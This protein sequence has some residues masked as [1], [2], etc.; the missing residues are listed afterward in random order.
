[1]AENHTR[2]SSIEKPVVFREYPKVVF[3]WPIAAA[4]LF[5]TLGSFVYQSGFVIEQVDAA[6]A[7]TESG[8]AQISGYNAMAGKVIRPGWGNF[9]FILFFLNVLILAYDFD[10]TKGVAVFLG[11]VAV[12]L[13]L[14]YLN[15]QFQMWGW[16][17]DQI[18]KVNITFN[19]HFMWATALMG[20]MTASVIFIHAKFNW[21]ELTHNELI[22]RKR[23]LGDTKRYPALNCRM[24][25]EIPDVMEYFFFFG[26]GRLVFQIPGEN[27]AHVLEHVP[28]VD[29]RELQI[30]EKLG[31]MSIR[32]ESPDYSPGDPGI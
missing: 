20:L 28:F 18:S 21:W 12:V 17:S 26:C 25:K 7:S 10:V 14:L 6:V 24:M 13:G 15:S 32:H 2:A 30:K 5:I 1:M 23:F 16:L 3:L 31:S 4:A 19:L 8:E 22:F 11:G 29:R 27:R 9:F